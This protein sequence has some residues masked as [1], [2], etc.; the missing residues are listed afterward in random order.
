MNIGSIARDQSGYTL[1]E[2]V[3]SMALFVGVL[4]PLGAA[5]G[6]L[7]LTDDSD[8]THYAL[9]VAET[10]I[11]SV[12]PR[13]EVNGSTTNEVDGLRVVKEV[14]IEGSLVTVSISV[15]SAK[16]PERPLATLQKTFL[17]YP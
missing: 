12:I 4:I 14:T 5:V 3:V 8:M 9:Q 17:A 10:E 7:M 1:L 13:N 2:T 15:A 11:C 16:K 6:K